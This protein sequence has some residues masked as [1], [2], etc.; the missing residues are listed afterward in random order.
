MYYRVKQE[1]VKWDN[2]T[3]AT[4]KNFC[5]L[6]VLRIE[7]LHIISMDQLDKSMLMHL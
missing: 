7:A 2:Q 3:L 6:F 1:N 5:S 4:N